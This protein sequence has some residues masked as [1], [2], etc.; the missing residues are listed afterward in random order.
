[1]RPK[2]G[3]PIASDYLPKSFANQPPELWVL[4]ADQRLLDKKLQI[5]FDNPKKG[6]ELLQDNLKKLARI[7]EL[8]ALQNSRGN[9]LPVTIQTYL[10]RPVK[11]C[12]RWRNCVS[13]SSFNLGLYRKTGPYDLQE[14]EKRELRKGDI[15]TFTLHNDSEQDYYC[16][17]IGISSNGAINAIFPHP[18]EGMEYALVKADEKRELTEDALLMMEEAG[19]S[20]KIIVSI[21]PIDV[22][23]FEQKGFKRDRGELNPLEQLLTNVTHGDRG[24][25]RV[26]EH[27]DEWAAGLVTFKVK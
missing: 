20:I 6:V 13:L 11:S 27:D 21:R 14:I 7:R 9:I 12:P 2:R 26:S 17:L 19:E 16:Y 4:T 23:L 10:L 5:K 25:T 3:L 1:M 24:L 22:L 15:L 18:D 8:K